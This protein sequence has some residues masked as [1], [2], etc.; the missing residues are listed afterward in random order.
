MFQFNDKF[1]ES[2]KF[3]LNNHSERFVSLKFQIHYY[4]FRSRGTKV[5]LFLFQFD[6]LFSS[7][8]LFSWELSSP[9]GF[10]K[11]MQ[12]GLS[13]KERQFRHYALFDSGLRFKTG[14]GFFLDRLCKIGREE[15]FLTRG[16]FHSHQPTFLLLLWIFILNNINNLSN[17]EL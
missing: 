1:I 14:L 3:L 17:L 11:R 4:C 2:C 12:Y 10:L 13:I 7:W 8:H 5:D 16:F 9:Q 15:S 6:I